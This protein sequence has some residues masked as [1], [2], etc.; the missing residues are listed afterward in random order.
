MDDNRRPIKTRSAGWAKHITDILVKRDISPNQI[1]VASIAFALAGVVAL[2][3]DSGVI[4]SICCAIGIQL[5]LLCNLFDG[6]VAIEGGK[7]SDIGSL[8]NEFPDRI[9][10]SLLI[11][12][13]G[14]AIGQSDLGWF[15]ALAAA[16]TAYVR[17]FGGSIGL[18]QTF[19]GPMAK[20][21]RMAVMTA[22]L[23]LN[24][25][26]AKFYGTHYVL[27]IALVVIAL[28]SVATCVTR[29]L[30]IAKQLK[31]TDHVDQ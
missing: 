29:T 28:G 13:L 27:L 11:V 26:E 17:V 14:Y 19:I 21:H 25:I 18:K 20:Q 24:A 30:A 7:K 16:L 4:G 12:G 15:A 6:M 1:S 31:G 23:L 10:D 2:N 22:G 9:A 8:Y 5:R 3:I